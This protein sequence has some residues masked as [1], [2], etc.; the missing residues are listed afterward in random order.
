[1]GAVLGAC[2]AVVLG[3][4]E[5]QLAPSC[6]VQ[7]DRV[8]T[9]P[10]EG[11]AGAPTSCPGP[12]RSGRTRCGEIECGPALHCVESPLPQCEPGCTSDLHCGGRDACVRAPG[13]A[14]GRCEPCAQ[15][16]FQDAAA[17]CVVPGRTG[18]TECFFAPCT[19]GSF[20]DPEQHCA[21]GCASDEN[22]GPTEYCVRAAGAVLG[23]CR[24]CY[25]PG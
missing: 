18:E 21:P 6:A 14:S 15:Q 13:E 4:C 12:A 11:D 8:E 7:T 5:L 20:C 3:A 22:C 24:S 17:G 19:A 23:A 2:G 25:A 10:R 16:R 9:A 1:M